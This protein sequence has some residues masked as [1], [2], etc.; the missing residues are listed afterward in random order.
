M[1]VL[2]ESGQEKLKKN[3]RKIE[4]MTFFKIIYQGPNNMFEHVVRAIP[5]V[6]VNA[7]DV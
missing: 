7:V 1:G 6:E 3:V 2:C 4:K 5:I